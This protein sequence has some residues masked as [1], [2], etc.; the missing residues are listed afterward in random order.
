MCVCVCDVHT[1]GRV[2][3]V[4]GGGAGKDQKAWTFSPPATHVLTLHVRSHSVQSAGRGE[5]GA[6]LYKQNTKFKC[7]L[8]KSPAAEQCLTSVG[9]FSWA[10]AG[11]GRAREQRWHLSQSP[12]AGAPRA[13]LKPDLDS[14]PR[15][16]AGVP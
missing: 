11:P 14:N 1:R 3:C 6:N 15:C 13:G 16:P 9:I 7:S 4:S 12:A 10:T 8:Q 5:G 2:V